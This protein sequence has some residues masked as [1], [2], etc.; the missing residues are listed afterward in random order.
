[1]SLH[2]SKTK[3]MPV[4]TR[5]KGQDLTVTLPAIRKHKQAVEETT[6]YKILGVII[7]S[8][9]SWSIQAVVWWWVAVTRQWCQLS[10]V[11]RQWCLWWVIP[12]QWCQRW[13]I[14]RQWSEGGWY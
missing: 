4:T 8:T 1:M 11:L 6:S 9:P 2:S 13:V 10:M 7:D 14:L 5:Q 3:W 12:G